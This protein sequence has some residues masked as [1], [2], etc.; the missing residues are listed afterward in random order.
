[1]TVPAE[2]RDSGRCGSGE[3]VLLMAYEQTREQL[4]RIGLARGHDL[5]A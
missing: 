3:R 4:L 2:L 1:M 5:R